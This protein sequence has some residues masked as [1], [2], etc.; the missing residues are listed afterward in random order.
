MKRLLLKKTAKLRLTLMGLVVASSACGEAEDPDDIEGPLV[1]AA[2]NAAPTS[3]SPVTGR[4]FTRC[5]QGTFTVDTTYDLRAS[6]IRALIPDDSPS[7]YRVIEGSGDANSNFTIPN[8]PDGIS[9]VLNLDLGYY[10]TDQH[11]FDVHD[12][13]RLRCAPYPAFSQLPTPVTYNLTGMTPFEAAS[14]RRSHQTVEVV[15]H[16]LGTVNYALVNN[17]L[18][19]P[20]DTIIDDTIDWGEGYLLPD[21]TLGDDVYV[22]HRKTEYPSDYFR[23]R[24]T[25]LTALVDIFRAR[26]FSVQDGVPGSISGSFQNLTPNRALSLSIDRAPFEANFHGKVTQGGLDVSIVTERNE[27]VVRVDMGSTARGTSSLNTLVNG[28]YADPFPPSLKRTSVVQYFAHQPVLLTNGRATLFS[29]QNY[30]RRPFPGPIDP[31]PILQVPATAQ[32]GAA[33]FLEG[34]MVPFTSTSPVAVSWSSVSGA[35]SY[36]LQVLLADGSYTTKAIFRTVGTS[37]AMPASLFQDGEFYIFR[38]SAVRS[39]NVYQKGQIIPVDISSNVE[40]LSGRFLFSSSCGDGVVQAGEVCDTAGPSATCNVDCTASSCGDGLSNP[41]AG[42][43]CDG[44][45]S[46]LLGCDRDCT[47]VVCGDGYVNFYAHEDC[48]DGNNVDDGNGCGADCEYNNVC[49]NFVVESLTEQCDTGGV[50]T[51]LCTTECQVSY[52]GDGYVN[53]A[54]GEQCDDGFFDHHRCNSSCRWNNP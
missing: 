2:A 30:H 40:L 8:V 51:S 44:A 53:P 9:Y 26:G 33:P 39:G 28:A 32:L 50:D 42:E 35:T 29:L 7:G 54:A 41:A 25:P 13:P 47:P 16:S 4:W 10:V 12:E 49:G 5:K 36:R 21:A 43:A 48:D 27:E 31:G 37:L 23:Y 6:V 38:L 22:L 46:D 11:I 3:T 20:E 52:C 19:H 34:G 24:S 17:D 14:T 18:V 1:A 45:G 15:S